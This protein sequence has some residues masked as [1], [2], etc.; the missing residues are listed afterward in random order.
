[1]TATKR[2]LAIGKGRMYALGGYRGSVTHVDEIL[3]IEGTF[4]AG[5]YASQVR[6]GDSALKNSLVGGI[7]AVTKDEVGTA[8]DGSKRN[9]Q[10]TTE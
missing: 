2:L 10:V 7:S 3:K 8:L 6:P 4:C 5:L 1:M 9:I